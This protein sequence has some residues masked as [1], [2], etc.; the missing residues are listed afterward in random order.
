MRLKDDVLWRIVWSIQE[1]KSINSISHNLH[2]H[3]NT[4]INTWSRYQKTKSVDYNENS[5]YVLTAPQMNYLN[6]LIE[7][8]PAMFLDEYQDIMFE[9]I[10]V[11][12]SQTTLYRAIKELG[13]TNQKLTIVPHDSDPNQSADYAW[14][15]AVYTHDQLVFIDEMATDER[16]KVRKR[17]WGNKGRRV[18]SRGVYLKGKRYSTM[19]ILHMTGL[20]HYV[21]HGSFDGENLVD[22]ADDF[23]IDYMQPYPAAKSV[24][25]LDNAS[26]HKNND[27]IDRLIQKGCIVEFLPPYSPWLNPVEYAFSKV[28]KTLRR[29]GREWTRQGLSPFMIIGRAFDSVSPLDCLNWVRRCGY[30]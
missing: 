10:G 24:L 3:R 1:G 22:F 29:E 17:G 18:R 8:Q 21:V 12:V 27:F 16:S 25:V 15:M 30:M 14:K 7:S 19:G 20:H 23:L 28:K 26:S 11:R 6:A 5:S 9:E 2:V 4:V 13:I